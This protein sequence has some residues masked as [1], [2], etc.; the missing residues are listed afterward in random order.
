M[1]I[2]LVVGYSSPSI[3]HIIDTDQQRAQQSV[4]MSGS[5]AAQVQVRMRALQEQLGDAPGTIIPGDVP[6][7]I[8]LQLG[9]R[10][11][12][13][14]LT[15]FRAMAVAAP[16]ALV[17]SSLWKVSKQHQLRTRAA[18]LQKLVSKHEEEGSG[19]RIG[20]IFPEFTHKYVQQALSLLQTK[21]DSQGSLESELVFGDGL[22]WGCCHS[23][24]SVERIWSCAVEIVVQALSV[25]RSVIPA[26]RIRQRGMQKARRSHHA[27][28]NDSTSGSSSSSGSEAGDD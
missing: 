1:V 25:E 10:S 27:D 6:R 23:T 19:C 22:E 11:C 21:T 12:Q 14:A 17:T 2:L 5:I 13:I 24:E 20:C 4:L 18:L 8:S 26:K 3:A 15:T 7:K 16:E 28:T 9:R